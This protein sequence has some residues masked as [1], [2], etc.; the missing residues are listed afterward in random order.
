MIE[1]RV[2]ELEAGSEFALGTELSSPGSR[3]RTFW[4]IS[5]GRLTLSIVAYSTAG[6]DPG[7]RS[8]LAMLASGAV[9]CSSAYEADGIQY[10][11]VARADM[12]VRLEPVDPAGLTAPERAAL[13]GRYLAYLRR[14]ETSRRRGRDERLVSSASDETVAAGTYVAAR[15]GL[16]FARTTG[17][18]RTL[19]E[20]IGPGSEAVALAGSI[21]LKAVDDVRLR[22]V[23]A[24]QIDPGAFVTLVER[25]QRALWRAYVAESLR[26]AERLAARRA[27]SADHD[28]RAMARE[29]FEATHVL[30]RHPVPVDPTDDPITAAARIVFRE[31]GVEIAV[32]PRLSPEPQ[33]AL[34]SLATASSVIL[35]RIKLQG[36]W[37]RGEHGPMVA[38]TTAGLPV[39][40]LPTAHGIGYVLIDPA[41]PSRRRP[42]EAKLAQE[43]DVDA[44]TVTETLPPEGASA[45]ALLWFGVRGSLRDFGRILLLGGVSGL[46]AT[47][48]PLAI[49]PLVDTVLPAGLGPILVTVAVLLAL[50]ALLGF[51]VETVGNF[52]L[53]RVQ[54]RVSA[55]LQSA[56]MH[57]LIGLGPGFFRRYATADLADRAL[58]IDAIEQY[59]T[60]ATLSALVTAIFSFVS[61]AVVVVVDP[62]IGF[63]CA[64]LAAI[65]LGAF[66]VQAALTV[67]LRR[68]ILNRTGFL[69]GFMYQTLS[70][71]AKIRVAG[72]RGRVFV[73]WL[74]R[75]VALRRTIAVSSK[76][77]YRFGI[78][79]AVWPSV[80][81]LA[82]ITTIVLFQNGAVRPGTFLTVVAAFSQM[83]GSLLVLG[84]IVASVVW[85]VPIYERVK[86]IVDELPERTPGAGDPGTLSGAIALRDVS[87]TYEGASRPAVDDINLTIEP[88]QFVAIVG[89][90]GSGKSTLTRLLLAFELPTRGTITYDGHDLATLDVVSVRRQIGSVL[91]TA[92]LL[93]GSIYDNISGTNLLT[94]EEA[95][96]AARR[97]GI[98]SDIERLPMGMDTS[99]G[100][101]GGGLS[102]G[103]RQRIVV[104]RALA[105]SPRIIFFDE[106]TSALDN[107]T[108]A[109]V[110]ESMARLEATRI[111]IAHRLTTVVDADRI[112]VMDRG[113]IVDEG[114]YEELMARPG[115]FRTLAER[116][117]A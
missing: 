28:A 7:S 105:R 75:Y 17:A 48:V 110:S 34:R 63:V 16:I 91:Q 77:E 68:D 53:V 40:L 39:S 8:F 90:S 58:G 35:R 1:D 87:F 106:A 84:Y 69:A 54:T 96:E 61:F 22:V 115:L 46:L 76:I 107:A 104:A 92:Q 45:A 82:V 83:L 23:D 116:Q 26:D 20:T 43:I 19:G 57:R 49:G 73:R 101:G 86:P 10:R 78:F 33:S 98:A 88:G 95:W 24:A 81:T 99:L 32:P 108:Q 72:A 97:A 18:A 102:G 114:T 14:D 29:M 60:D 47:A 9:L 11:L 113:R 36:S 51:V 94:R 2:V 103:Q 6:S 109:T 42:V 117:R 3:E 89:P 4:R 66:A 21:G 85:V 5:G 112:V 13:V 12:N 65:T 52:S 31:I 27:A 79:A 80:S 64:I 100:A 41:D 56:V 50:C 111:V 44:F 62:V 15:T 30:D 55:T 74:H 38:V 67:P 25:L 37:W 71:I 93:P 70:G 59:I